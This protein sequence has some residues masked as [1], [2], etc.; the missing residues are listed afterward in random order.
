M[1]TAFFTSM[2]LRFGFKINE[3]NP[4]DFAYLLL[5]T[6][7]VTTIV[8][9]TVTFLTKPESSDVLIS[10]YRRVKPNPTFWKP[11]ASKVIDVVP[12]KDG[13]FSFANWISGVA[14]IYFMLFG[15]GKLL[16]GEPLLGLLLI[17]CGFISGAIIYRNMNKKGWET[18]SN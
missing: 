18:L 11:I 16:L 8:W 1:I 3:S 7:A 12:Q 2:V 5:I 10:F 17:I 13:L 4:V 6:T 14:L 15:I 9:I